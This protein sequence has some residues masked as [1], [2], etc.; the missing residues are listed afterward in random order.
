MYEDLALPLDVTRRMGAD[1]GKLKDTSIEQD[2]IR[3][4]APNLAF[5]PTHTD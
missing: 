1:H 4:A 5:A 3:K 2:L